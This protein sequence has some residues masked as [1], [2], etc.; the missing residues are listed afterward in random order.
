[1][2]RILILLALALLIS[3]SACTAR[4]SQD[5][6]IPVPDVGLSLQAPDSWLYG[7]ADMGLDSPIAIASG[8]TPE[9]YELLFG[10]EGCDFYAVDP[11]SGLICYIMDV[12][13]PRLDLSEANRD[14]VIRQQIALFNIPLEPA[15]SEVIRVNECS[16]VHL[17]YTLP[18]GATH[19]YYLTNGAQSPCVIGFVAIFGEIPQDVVTQVL[20]S[21]RL[22]P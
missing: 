6:A 9:E 21:I 3:C 20:G 5:A 10:E 11:Y 22:L 14:N 16:F 4:A 15:V 12:P 2:K 13:G 19:D 17:R 7:T 8:M 18:E 1:M